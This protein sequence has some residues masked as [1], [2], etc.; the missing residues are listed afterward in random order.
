MARQDIYISYDHSVG[1]KFAKTLNRELRRRGFS[2]Y[3]PN[4][5]KNDKLTEREMRSIIASAKDVIVVLNDGILNALANDSKCSVAIEVSIALAMNAHIIPI[6]DETDTIVA[7]DLPMDL[8]KLALKQAIGHR[9][10]VTRTLINTLIDL[11]DSQP[12]WLN[13]NRGKVIFG[14]IVGVMLLISLGVWITWNLFGTGS[15][16]MDQSTVSEAIVVQQTP[17]PPPSEVIPGINPNP[18]TSSQ[19]LANARVYKEKG[20]DTEADKAYRSIFDFDSKECFGVYLEYAEFVKKSKVFEKPTEH[21]LNVC[22]MHPSCQSAKLIIALEQIQSVSNEVKADR[23]I[24]QFPGFLPALVVAMDLAGTGK[25]IV[26]RAIALSRKSQFEKA[27][28]IDELV[29]LSVSPEDKSFADRAKVVTASIKPIYWESLAM[30]SVQSRTNARFLALKIIDPVPPKTMTLQFPT[31]SVEIPVDVQ[32]NPLRKSGY[33]L[34]E[35]PRPGKVKTGAPS[36]T[37]RDIAD[38]RSNDHSGKLDGIDP[39]I[40]VTARLSYIDAKGR[41]FEFP[42]K[43]QIF[44]PDTYC[45]V[46]IYNSGLPG[47]QKQGQPVIVFRPAISMNLFQISAFEK[48]PFVTTEQV[49]GVSL[50]FMSDIESIPGLIT[51]GDVVLYAK[52]IADDGRFIENIRIL[53]SFPKK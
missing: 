27:G 20:K 18:S 35:L 30:V 15:N 12:S 41:P 53:V 47:M 7:S 14:S 2:V 25:F 26:D 22:N 37:P 21:L 4:H 43:I 17:K 32:A 39:M 45:S 46:N 11:I 16:Q 29:K 33:V 40:P 36:F 24:E 9:G 3:I 49:K 48:G 42:E 28:G 51:S 50:L 1:S 10:K 38:N 19:F 5:S 52:G 13:V 8:K 44:G 23:I 31:G 34:L 6:I